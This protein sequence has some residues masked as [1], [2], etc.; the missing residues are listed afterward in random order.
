M[1]MTNERAG[2]S[3]RNAEGRVLLRLGR[4]SCVW[5]Q[6]AVEAAPFRERRGPRLLRI[7][8][9][10]LWQRRRKRRARWLEEVEVYRHNEQVRARPYFRQD[11]S[12]A[13]AI[14][15]LLMSR[16]HDEHRRRHRDDG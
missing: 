10:I 13:S 5:D 1:T 9:V 7:L 3:V 14:A 15:H 4:L 16:L 2:F 8:R 12:Q 11:A 6:Q